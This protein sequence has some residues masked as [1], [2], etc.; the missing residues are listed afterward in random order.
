MSCCDDKPPQG[1][2]KSG[3]KG[4]VTG[5][6][7][8]MLL[9]A[10]VVAGGLSLGWDQLVLLGIAPV[11]VSILPCLVMCG[12]MCMMKCKD[13]KGKATDQGEVSDVQAKVEASPI[14]SRATETITRQ[15]A[16][17][18]APTEPPASKLQA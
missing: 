13:K 11:L 16:D 15:V 5:P 3:L 2:Q 1:Q 7:R 12:A 6:R 18:N 17:R 14:A 10:V 9:G 8:W 4:L